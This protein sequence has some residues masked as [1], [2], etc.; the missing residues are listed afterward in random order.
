MADNKMVVGDFK[1]AKIYQMNGVTLSA[2]TPDAQFNEDMMTLKARLR[3]AFLIRTVDQ[4]GFLLC[5]DI[6]AALTKL[7]TVTP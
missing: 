1:F 2:G 6:D 4:T 3:I 5:S 7:S